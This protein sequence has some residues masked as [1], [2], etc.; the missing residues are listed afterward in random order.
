MELEQNLERRTFLQTLGL[1]ALILAGCG[2]G[3]RLPNVVYILAD[4]MGYGDLSCLNEKSRLNTVHMDRLASG[5]MVFTDAHSGSAVCTPTRYGILTGRYSWR[6]QLKSGGLTGYSPPLIPPDRL[7]VAS[8]LKK[9]GY[10]TACIGK[11]HVGLKWQFNEGTGDAGALNS[12][13]DFTRPVL[14]GP[15][16]LGFDYF[17]GISASLDMPPY[18]Y[19]ENDRITAL[20]DRVT[21][22]TSYQELWRKGPAGSDFRHEE[23]LSKLTDRAVETINQYSKDPFFI[24]IAFP[25]PHTPILPA[26]P[27]M[28]KSL[29]NIYGDFVLQV[30]AMV[31]KI[32][33]AIEKNAVTGN[34]LVILASDNGCSPRADFKE[35][36]SVG[37]NPNHVFRGHKADIFEGGHHIPFIAYW[38]GHIEKG[39]G[40]NDPVCLT[41][42][43]ATC[44]DIVGEKLPDHA[45]ED[46]VSLLPAFL[47]RKAK[48]HSRDAIVHHSVNGSFSIRQGRWKLVLCPGSGG[49]SDPKPGSKEEQYLPPFQLYDLKEDIGEERN[50]AETNPEIVNRLANT[51]IKIV[52]KGRSTPG[53]PQKNDGPEHWPELNWMKFFGS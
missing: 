48:K 6:S 1:G 8:L 13:V 17:Y 19:I 38:P 5:G 27:F 39:T 15:T 21:E 12:P 28:G 29:T 20:P 9:K 42:L 44:A 37:H 18:V 7:T 50:L 16:T 26:E 32:T 43:V 14:N 45:G 11:W 24:Y 10:R 33:E 22:N 35:L 23:V 40:C 2:Q 30:D 49:W 52:R 34:T 31:G 51:L 25:A 53:S 47:G 4:D 3:S 46:S 36:E 41:D